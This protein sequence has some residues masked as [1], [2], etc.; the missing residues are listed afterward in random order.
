MS[1]SPPIKRAS[2]LSAG[3]GGQ[4][5]FNMSS[6]SKEAGGR[7]AWLPLV[8]ER[9]AER[10]L[11]QRS[12]SLLMPGKPGYQHFRPSTC[13]QLQCLRSRGAAAEHSTALTVSES[14]TRTSKTAGMIHAKVWQ[15]R[16]ISVLL[17]NRKTTDSAGAERFYDVLWPKP[18]IIQQPTST[19]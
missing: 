16:R 13:R 19:A 6:S 1:Y 10:P 12:L 2:K 18:W 4:T 17:R 3:R 9:K 7:A 8:V 14:N 11:A 5:A 15:D